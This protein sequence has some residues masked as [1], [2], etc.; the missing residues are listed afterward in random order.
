ML[1]K[2]VRDLLDGE[3]RGCGNRSHAFEIALI[4]RPPKLQLARLLA[5][6]HLGSDVLGQPQSRGLKNRRDRRANDVFSM[7]GKIRVPTRRNAAA[8]IA[9][10]PSESYLEHTCE[11]PLGQ[12]DLGDFDFGVWLTVAVE[13]A[14]AL[15][16][17]IAED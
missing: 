17:L 7:D 9:I 1:G 5:D 2:T 3:L 16:G 11:A 13:F 14:N 15:L 10:V 6:R 8:P 4:L 12:R